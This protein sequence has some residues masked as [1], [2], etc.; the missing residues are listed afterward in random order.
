MINQGEQNNQEED[1]SSSSSGQSIGNGEDDDP[2]NA[3]V[4]EDASEG[5][6]FDEPIGG[7]AFNPKGIAP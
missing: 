5:G 6:D 7:I 4:P 3:L 1:D 2:D